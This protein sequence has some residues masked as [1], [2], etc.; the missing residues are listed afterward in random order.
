[1]GGRS[2]E[3]NMLTRVT[4][5]SAEVVNQRSNKWFTTCDHDVLVAVAINITGNFI[6]VASEAFGMPG[7]ERCVAPVASQITATCANE[8]TRRAGKS[9][10]SLERRID[11]SDLHGRLPPLA[12]QS[13]PG[14]G[15]LCLRWQNQRLLSGRNHRHHRVDHLWQGHSNW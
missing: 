2:F 10:F 11:L 7:S 3:R 15:Q 1:M 14:G 5:L 12:S 8:N 9:A 6:D 13:V 4:K